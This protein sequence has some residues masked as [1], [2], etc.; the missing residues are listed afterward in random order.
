M[1]SRNTIAVFDLDGTLTRHDTYRRFLLG[2][3]SAHPTKLFRFG[4]LALDALAHKIGRRSNSW[5][6]ERFLLEILGGATHT[7]IALFADRFVSHLMRTGMRAGAIR[8]IE[9][10]RHRGDRL[11]L[12][13]A[14][15]DL[16]VER[17]AS[18]L[19]MDHCICTK[20]TRTSDGRIAGTLDGANCYGEEKIRRLSSW[21]GNDRDRM[22]VLAYG[23]HRSDLP[24]LEWAD[25]GILVNPSRRLERAAVEHGLETVR[26]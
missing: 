6:K 18:Q 3:A 23:D 1:Q 10:H 21:V 4:P 20:A 19:Q 25:R 2:Y 24:L 13:S 11:I 22:H 14:S 15:L 5:L 17:I 8:A 16:Y 12:V 7:E 26:W 9:G